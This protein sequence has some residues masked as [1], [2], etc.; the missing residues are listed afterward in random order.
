MAGTCRLRDGRS[1]GFRK[2]KHPSR[3]QGLRSGTCER[4]RLRF[5]S[6]PARNDHVRRHGHSPFHGERHALFSAISL[7]KI[8]L[9]WLK[10]FVELPATVAELT[11]LLTLAGVEVEGIETRGVNIDKVVVAQILESS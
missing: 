4:F 11:E 9:N 1:G 6:R 3:R 10:E 2:C 7:M 5:R 8:S